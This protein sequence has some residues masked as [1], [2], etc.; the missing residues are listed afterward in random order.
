MRD[1]GQLSKDTRTRRKHLAQNLGISSP[2]WAGRVL[3]DGPHLFYFFYD[4]TPLRRFRFID[5][6]LV[7]GDSNLHQRISML[8]CVVPSRR[9]EALVI[10]RGVQWCDALAISSQLH[11]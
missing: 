11:S 8:K 1:N 9:F 3:R 2:L 10:F 7:V 6:V 5:R 4:M